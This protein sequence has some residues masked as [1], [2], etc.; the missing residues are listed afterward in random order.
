MIISC[1]QNGED[2]LLNRVF[3]GDKGFYIDVG[4]CHPLV[5]SVTKI[6]YDRGWNGINIEP[7]PRMHERLKDNRERDVSLNVALSNVVGDICYYEAPE[8]LPLSTTSVEAAR[9][10]LEHNVPLTK[11]IVEGLTLKR[12]CSSYYSETIDFLKIDVEGHELEVIQGGDWDRF[13]PRIVLVEVNRVTSEPES[14][15]CWEKI[16]LNAGYEFATY[17]GANNYYVREEDASLAD[18]LKKPLGHYDDYIQ[19]KFVMHFHWIHKALIDAL[20]SKNKEGAIKN[21]ARFLK[22]FDKNPEL[23]KE[24]PFAL[25]EKLKQMENLDK[26]SLDNRLECVDRTSL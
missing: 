23:F 2:I 18:L 6:F 10:L 20:H 15:E 26:A 11:K 25:Y 8:H 16:I 7:N 24:T 13:R 22:L 14:I 17:D 5:D 4:A 3:P 19:I 9:D 1:A 21:M 12:V